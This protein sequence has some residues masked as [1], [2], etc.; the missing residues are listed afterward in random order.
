MTAGKADEDISFNTYCITL[1]CQ[2]LFNSI[3]VQ[4]NQSLGA[5]CSIVAS[6]QLQS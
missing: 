2:L 5:I 4:Q 3:Q 1:N 6:K